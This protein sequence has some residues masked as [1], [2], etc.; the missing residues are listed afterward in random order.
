[1]K[2]F[3]LCQRRS[4]NFSSLRYQPRLRLSPPSF[5]L[6]L[7]GCTFNIGKSVELRRTPQRKCLSGELAL[8]F[9]MAWQ[10][11]YMRA[12][13]CAGF[14]AVWLYSSF[15]PPYA[16]G[17]TERPGTL[18]HSSMSATQHTKLDVRHG[19]C[20]KEFATVSMISPVAALAIPHRVPNSDSGYLRDVRGC[21]ER[22]TG[23]RA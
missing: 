12:Q 2:R 3:N 18:Q 1:M 15:H 5:K 22:T 6:F 7:N 11:S 14:I 10:G 9:V 17:K 16:R 13:E 20:E 19:L 23:K 8:H 4:S 21:E